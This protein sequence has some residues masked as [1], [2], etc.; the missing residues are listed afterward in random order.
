V[1]RPAA[2]SRARTPGWRRRSPPSLWWPWSGACVPLPAEHPAADGRQ[3]LEDA[4][5]EDDHD[6]RGEVGDPEL[7]S[8]PDEEDGQGGVGDEGKDEDAVVERALE[9]GAQTAEGGVD[10]HHHP[11]GHV[12][13]EVL[14]DRGPQEDGEEGAGEE[15]D[16]GNHG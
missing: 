13:R 3:V 11:D 8:H 10:R 7:V 14:G 16:E 4:Y 1:A 9:V 5:A 2:G 12:G 6:S 15:A